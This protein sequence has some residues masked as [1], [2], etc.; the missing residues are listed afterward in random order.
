MPWRCPATPTTESDLARLIDDEMREAGLAIA[1]DARAALV[2][3]LGGDRLASRSEI[4]QARALSR[5]ARS[6]V[7]LDDV[8]AVVADASTLALD[9]L[10]DAAFAGRTE[11]TRIPVRPRRAPPARRRARSCRPR[12]ARSR[13]C[14]RP[15]SRSKTA[16]RSSE[17]HRRHPAVRPFQPQGRGR[18]SARDRGPRRGSSARW[19]SLPTPLLES[20]KQAG[21]A[22]VIAQRTLLSL[23]VNAR[24]KG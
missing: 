11:R 7:E 24:R 22:D 13:S 12:C 15:G 5:A 1:P 17:A 21:L 4:A 3:L 14:T 20:R 10:I 18:G 23:A 16:P 19:R 9:G 8:M 6:S 2:P